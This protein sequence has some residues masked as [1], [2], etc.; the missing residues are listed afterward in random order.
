[1][2]DLGKDTAVELIEPGLYRGRLNQDWEIWGPNG[3]YIASVA[4]RAACAH[5]E[6]PRP[7]SFSCQYVAVGEFDDVDARVVTT[8]RTKRAEAVTVE[9]HQGDRLLL[10]AQ[11]WFI[12]ADHAGLEHDFAAAP[13]AE[14]W[15][16]IPTLEERIAALPEELRTGRS[17][18]FWSNFRERPTVWYDQWEDRPA[19]EPT[20]TN[21][22]SYEPRPDT[23][24]VAVD[25]ARL[26]VLADTVSWPAATRAYSG[27]LPWMAPSL[28][29]NIQFH[30]F[31]PACDW[32]LMHGRAD[33]STEGLFG[34]RGE[35]WSDDNTLLASSS[36]QCFY[37][38]VPLPG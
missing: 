19:G 4:M 13:N 28:D 21:W 34:F 32:L 25:A 37:R 38:A 1:M 22:L 24:D 6:L 7:A 3:G 30:R 11:A 10:T 36:G 17:F 31:R 27:P 2:G 14:H 5:A 35:V 33:V 12:D 18:P 15:S 16:K 26:I 8:R 29:L 9:L 20:F 23:A